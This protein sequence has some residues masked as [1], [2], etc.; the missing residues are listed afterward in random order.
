MSIDYLKLISFD[1]VNFDPA[2]FPRLD[3]ATKC[4][5]RSGRASLYS[6][7]VVLVPDAKYV[8]R[9]PGRATCG[10]GHSDETHVYLLHEDGSV[11]IEAPSDMKIEI[12]GLVSLREIK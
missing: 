8:L 7:S 12:T 3:Y 1:D 10:C 2:Q 5:V 6:C 4:R 9:M 11:I